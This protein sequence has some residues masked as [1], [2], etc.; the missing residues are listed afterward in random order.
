LSARRS[1]R[2]VGGAVDPAAAASRPPAYS[3]DLTRDNKWIT[4][5]ETA[6]DGDIWLMT[7]E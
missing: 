4:Y 2:R 1:S 5:T 6:T 7:R 3:L